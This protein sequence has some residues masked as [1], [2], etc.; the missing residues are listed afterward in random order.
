MNDLSAALITL[1][2]A[3]FILVLI[4][5]YRHSSSKKKKKWSLGLLIGIILVGFGIYEFPLAVMELYEIT[6]NYF[7]LSFTENYLLWTLIC[8]ICILIGGILI[9]K[10]KRR[11][12]AKKKSS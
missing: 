5:A 8:I 1:G 6:Q 9:I 7:G 11:K 12:N 2:I 10:S 3:I 4:A